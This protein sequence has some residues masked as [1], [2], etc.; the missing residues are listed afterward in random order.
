MTF[1]EQIQ[2]NTYATASSD[3]GSSAPPS[4]VGD[5]GSDSGDD[6][7]MDLEAEL[8]KEMS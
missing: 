4:V 3:I 7:E 2:Y 8:E 6:D 1:R 5:G